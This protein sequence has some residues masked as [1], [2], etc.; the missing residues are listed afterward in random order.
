MKIK[1][2]AK[3]NLGLNVVERRPD[4]YHNLETVFYPVPIYD[5][6]EI[7]P[8]E[9]DVTLSVAGAAVDCD[10]EK[11]LVVRAYRLLAADS[12]LPPVSITLTKNIPMQA[13]M[14][15]GSSDCAATI[16]LLN[17]LFSLGMSSETMI[18]YARQ[19]G[20]DCA[21]FVD[22]R[23]AYA[24]GIGD[25]LTPVGFSFEG[26]TMVVVKPD[27]SV[28]TAEAYKNIHPRRPEYN[29]RDVVTNHPL[30]EWPAMLFNDFEDSVFVN[31]PE[32]PEIKQRLYSAGALYAAMS[33]SGSAMFGIFDHCPEREKISRLMSVS[34]SAEIRSSRI[35]IMPL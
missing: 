2:C 21:F 6:I 30:E 4:N 9:G 12:P 18:G 32:L 22:S 34:E 26:K 7:N 23:P 3:V 19:L 14:G 13:G 15:G 20:A 27:I 1:T 31:H 17:R 35:E 11:N 29:C 10:P 5:E 24:E 8:A 33:G 28:S 25:I 16:V